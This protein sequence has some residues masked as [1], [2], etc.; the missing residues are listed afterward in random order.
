[1]TIE[2]RCEKC[3][4]RY[5]VK[6]EM[7]GKKTKCRECGAD[8]EVPFPPLELPQEVTSGGSV[9]YRHEAGNRDFELA[10]GDD[11]N[12]ELISNHIEKHLGEVEGVFHELIS[13]MVHVDVHCVRPTEE[14][15]FHSL[16]TSGM[17]DRPMN[18]PDELSEFSYAELMVCLPPEWPLTEED[19]EDEN[20][21]WPVRWLKQLARFP[22]EYETWLFEGHTVPNGDPPE[23]FAD[24][25]GFCGWLIFPPLLAPDE[26]SEL[27]VSEE[28]TIYFFSIWPLYEG[29]MNLKLAK[30]TE[31]LLEK[32]AANQVC[33]VIDSD[34][35]DTSKRGWWPFG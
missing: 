11:Q 5:R 1:M 26:F 22:H 6:E 29:E 18:A 16:V 12:I 33:E 31:K 8:L 15:P 34:R 35:K 27:K 13:D 23:P 30:G 10:V 17:S 14:R 25:T 24:N 19:F 4:Q 7:A 28:K 32:F 21:Y 2:F 9:L 20:N 3:T